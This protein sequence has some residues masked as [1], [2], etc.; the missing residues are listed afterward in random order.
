MEYNGHHKNGKEGAAGTLG[1][2]ERLESDIENLEDPGEHPGFE[3]ID[4]VESEE[5][6]TVHGEKDEVG[7]Q[8]RH[9]GVGKRSAEPCDS[10]SE[11][12]DFKNTEQAAVL[13]KFG[14]K[15]SIRKWQEPIDSVGGE[16]QAVG[17]RSSEETAENL[18]D[19]E[20]DPG[21]DHEFEIIDQVESEEEGGEKETDDGA[22]D[23][24]GQQ[25]RQDGAA[26][27]DQDGADGPDDYSS[28]SDD[29]DDSELHAMLEK[30]IDRNSIKKKEEPT[31]G[32]PIIKMKTVLKGE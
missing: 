8:K 6:E 25:D 12:D 9:I 19:E 3:V 24:K 7:S 27:R 1:L 23:K 22:S 2:E 5:E 13:E 30:G 10:S 32:K 20:E 21:E 31:E 18:E 14:S 17:N 28:S 16:T 4:Q 11:D 29:F 26:E 15:N